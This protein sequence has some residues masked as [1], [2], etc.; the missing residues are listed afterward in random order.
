MNFIEGDIVEYIKVNND[1]QEILLIYYDNNGNY[2][3]RW[4]DYKNETSN[5]I[6]ENRKIKVVV[7]NKDISEISTNDVRL[8]I[9]IRKHRFTSDNHVKEEKRIYNVPKIGNP[10]IY[11]SEEHEHTS[12]DSLQIND[13]YN[14]YDALV[15]TYP[16]YIERNA[17]I[18]SDSAGNPIRQYTVRYKGIGMYAGESDV[19]GN[20]WDSNY[21][22]DKILLTSG[23]HGTEKSASYGL[24]LAI[25]SLFETQSDSA[26]Y[27]LNNLTLIIVPC[28]NIWGFNTTT[29][30]NYNDVNINRDAIDFTQSE[31]K[32][33]KNLIDSNSD[34]ILYIDVHGASGRGAYAE[35]FK[36]D[37]FDMIAKAIAKLQTA[38][39]DNWEE[40]VYSDTLSSY[41]NLRIVISS[42]TGTLASY[43]LSLGIPSFITETPRDNI[44]GG[45][46]NFLSACK[47]TKDMVINLIQMFG[48]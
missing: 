45:D 22:Y 26:K 32:A 10:A 7:R 40:T 28:L 5:I 12:I 43:G 29:R 38:L 35:I 42:F 24:A 16:D 39:K 44:S 30:N 13:L 3:T 27:I 1:N 20:L 2:I 8:M 33:F 23:V 37:Y 15:D 36:G 11:F 4:D 47:I 6:L 19:T 21:Y 9:S 41:P 46:E 14:I 31:T 18:G 48:A 17:D 25:K 34:A